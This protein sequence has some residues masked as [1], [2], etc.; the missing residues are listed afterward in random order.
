MNK[1]LLV[2]VL[3]LVLGGGY[4]LAKGKAPADEEKIEPVKEAVM[5]K[6]V[7]KE[8][9]VDGNEFAFVPKILSAVKGDTIRVTFTNTG[10]FPHNFVIDELNVLGKTIQP[11]QTDTVTFTVDKAG[12]FDYYCSVGT[13]KDKGMVGTLTV[14]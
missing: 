2:L 7:E 10:K 3:I 11:G 4:F 1:T 5:E 9:A 6:G 14:E 13:H 12:S 8:F